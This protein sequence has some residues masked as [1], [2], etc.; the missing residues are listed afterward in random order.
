MITTANVSVCVFLPQLLPPIYRYGYAMPF[1]NVQQTVRTI[2]FGTRNQSA[3]YIIIDIS[4][5]F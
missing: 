4:A 1:Y 2:I 5:V 3:S